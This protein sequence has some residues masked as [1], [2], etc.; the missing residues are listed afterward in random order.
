MS[1]LLLDES[2][3][4]KIYELGRNNPLLNDVAFLLAS[5]FVYLLPLVLVVLF[6]RSFQDKVNSIKIFLIAVLSWQVL[7]NAVG[8][9]LYASYGFRERPFAKLGI[10]ELLF[11]QPEKAFPS[12]HSAVIFAVMLAF[13]YYKYPKVGWLFLLLGIL[14]SMGRVMIG[15][16]YVGD[17]LAGWALGLIAF[18]II[19]YLDGPISR[20]LVLV[21]NWL[22]GRKSES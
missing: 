7:S 19:K 22:P 9:W 2:L 16:H 21:A 14:S 1:I 4:F 17:V 8:G 20:H 15:F 5:A 6:F 13:F 18:L 11:E 10:Q 12:D 3:T